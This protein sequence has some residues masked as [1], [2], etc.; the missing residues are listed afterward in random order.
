M[1][2]L[3]ENTATHVDTTTSEHVDWKLTI[4]QDSKVVAEVRV[5]SGYEAIAEA[6]LKEPPRRFSRSAML[7]YV[8]AVVGFFCSTCNGFDGSMFNAL[9]INDTFKSYYKVESTGAWAGI[10]TSIR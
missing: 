1:A 4:D 2:D 3:K 8:C 9:L 5:I 6:K 7:L 10:V